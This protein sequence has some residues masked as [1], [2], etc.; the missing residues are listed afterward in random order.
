MSFIVPGCSLGLMM[1]DIKDEGDTTT[2]D[3]ARMVDNIE[4]LDFSSDLIGILWQLVG[5]D[6]LHN[7]EI[8]FLPL[9]GESYC[10][11]RRGKTKLY[12]ARPPSGDLTLGLQSMATSPRGSATSKLPPNLSLAQTVVS[13]ADSPSTLTG[14]TSW[15]CREIDCYLPSAVSYSDNE[16]IQADDIGRSQTKCGKAI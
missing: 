13:G 3:H 6:L 1:E 4:A 14:S 5:V 10:R 15:N 11:K 8:F 16:A 2:L 9:P 12:V 7:N